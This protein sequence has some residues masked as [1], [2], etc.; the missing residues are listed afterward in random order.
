MSS[1]S[2]NNVLT[3]NTANNNG[4]YGIYL[5][6]SSNNNLAANTLNNNTN[7]IYIRDS[8]SNLFRDNALTVSGGQYGFNFNS[9]A[10]LNYTFS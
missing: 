1:H 5:Y 3:A 9:N 10:A 2:H 8:Y 4:Y 6:A 7:S